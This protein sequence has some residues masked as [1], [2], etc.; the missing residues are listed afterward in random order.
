MPLEI[1]VRKLTSDT[2][3]AFG[4]NDRGV[5]AAGKL[6][7]VN[8]IDFPALPLHRPEALYDLPTGGK[9][10]VQRAAGYRFTVKSGEVTFQD[11]EHTGT[12][13]RGGR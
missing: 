2:A 6:A 13:V 5:L 7:D 10:L 3:S 12:L 11:G 1:L 4:L 9:R 8:V